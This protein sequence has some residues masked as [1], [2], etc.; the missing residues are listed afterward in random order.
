[1]TSAKMAAV[2]LDI[3]QRG[4]SVLSSHRGGITRTG[5]NTSTRSRRKF[6]FSRVEEPRE[7]Q[8]QHEGQ[9]DADVLLTS[10]SSGSGNN[11]DINSDGLFRSE[12]L[13]IEIQLREAL[14][15]CT[16]KQPHTIRTAAAFDALTHIIPHLA[17]FRRVMQ[18][19]A[20]ELFASIYPKDVLAASP[21]HKTFFEKVSAQEVAIVELDG[22]L[23]EL[24]KKYDYVL[25]AQM[26]SGG[27]IAVIVNRWRKKLMFSAFQSWRTVAFLGMELKNASAA[28]YRKSRQRKHYM[29]VFKAWHTYTTRECLSR[30]RV[31]ER[32]AADQAQ[33]LEMCQ[34]TIRELRGKLAAMTEQ[35]K[36]LVDEN[37]RLKM[38]EAGGEAHAIVEEAA[39]ALEQVHAADGEHVDSAAGEPEKYA[40]E[41][42]GHILTAEDVESG[43]Y[44][45][46]SV[47]KPTVELGTIQG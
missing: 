24:Q 23:A 12:S 19:V 9:P 26:A 3:L 35:V 14:A 17:G 47:D 5:D 8:W 41:I 33:D 15:S 16:E 36:V 25:E 38:G 44:R 31:N 40:I 34:E 32:V 42:G 2:Q 30:L 27:S 18:T 20:L 28:T 6:R 43:A 39:S 10:R 29:S 22:N 45:G 1:M 46:I 37:S 21:V 13:A 4:A 11:N 7:S